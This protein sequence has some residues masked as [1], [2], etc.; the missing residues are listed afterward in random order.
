LLSVQVAH[1]IVGWDS[2]QLFFAR[3]ERGTEEN[4][5]S[6]TSLPLLPIV[7]A[8]LLLNSPPARA[9][10]PKIEVGAALTDVMV[11]IGSNDVT[12]FGLPSGEL[13][14]FNPSVYASFFVGSHLAIEPQVGVQVISTSGHTSHVANLTGQ[15]DY[16]VLGTGKSSPYVFGGAGVVDMSGSSVTPKTF[17]AGGGYRV[18]VGDRLAFRFDGHVTHLTEGGDNVIF[19]AVSIGGV[20]GSSR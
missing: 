17:S 19:F 18:P 2:S 4:M 16:F 14:F 15:V 8:C 13:D 20:F 10:E 11:G 3:D 9:A 6:H 12:I 5:R 1:Q 7:A